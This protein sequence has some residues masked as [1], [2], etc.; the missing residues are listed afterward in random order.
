M[1]AL[2]TT[3]PRLSESE[4]SHII[5]QD[6]FEYDSDGMNAILEQLCEE[7]GIAFDWE[8]N[9]D[10]IDTLIIDNEDELIAMY[11]GYLKVEGADETPE[12]EEEDIQ[13]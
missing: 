13:F 6:I 4:E 1:F 9:G 8:A 2:N 12:T 10:E 5:L 11:Q 7:E 3:F